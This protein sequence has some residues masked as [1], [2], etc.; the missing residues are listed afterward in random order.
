MV[1]FSGLCRIRKLLPDRR[2][3]LGNT[4]GGALETL[5]RDEDYLRVRR[6]SGEEFAA[7]DVRSREGVRHDDVLRRSADVSAEEV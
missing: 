3:Y 1:L 2:E 6:E 5:R 4:R 7:G